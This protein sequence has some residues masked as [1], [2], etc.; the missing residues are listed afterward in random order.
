[1][2]E[3]WKLLPSILHILVACGTPAEEELHLK[4]FFIWLS[5][6]TIS[7]LKMDMTA[8][9]ITAQTESNSARISMITA[10]SLLCALQ[11]VD[12]LLLQTH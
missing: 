2:L 5:V 4:E 1:M 9:L 3:M 10:A 6:P 7:H 8:W 11:I 12:D